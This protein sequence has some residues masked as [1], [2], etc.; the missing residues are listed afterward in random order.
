LRTTATL[1]GR[2]RGIVTD[3]FNMCCEVCSNVVHKPPKMLEIEI[4]QKQIDEARK[5]KEKM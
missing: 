5:E 3:W 2:G 4:D 1:T